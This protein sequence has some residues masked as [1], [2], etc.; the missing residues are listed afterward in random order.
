MRTDTDTA[1]T[2]RD[3]RRAAERLEAGGGLAA[4]A[5][6]AEALDAAWQ[7]W[8]RALPEQAYEAQRALD[9]ADAAIG[10]AKARTQTAVS[11]AEWAAEGEA[12]R[13]RA[14]VSAA[15]V[16]AID[17]DAARLGADPFAWS[18]SFSPMRRA[19]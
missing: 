5:E 4:L 8:Y 10:A 3:L 14:A 11:V 1:R 2:A 18:R 9:A 7:A 19:A 15:T 6:A 16:E 12:M 13:A 17:R